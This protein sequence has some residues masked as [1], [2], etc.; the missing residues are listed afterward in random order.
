MLQPNPLSQLKIFI[1]P[2]VA[3]SFVTNLVVLVSPIFMMQVLD[4]VVPSG[5]LNTLAMLLMVAIGA[6]TTH[7]FTEFFKEQSLT[8][9]A[10]WIEVIGYKSALQLTG[11]TR[12]TALENTSKI[13][14]FFSGTTASTLLNT[15]WIPLF[16]GALYLIH[17]YFLLLLF[18]IILSI[19][20][21]KTLMQIFTQDTLKLSASYMQ[22][23]QQTLKDISNYRIV[24]GLYAITENL[25]TLFT[26]IQAQRHQN[27]NSVTTA[28]SIRNAI[29]GFLRMSSQVLALALGASLVVTGQLS[30]G[31]MIGASII[32]AKTISTIEASINSYQDIKRSYAAYLGLSDTLTQKHTVATEVKALSGALRA[33]GLIFPRGGGASPRIDRISFSLTSGECLAIIGDSGSGKT[34]LLHALCGIAP[35]PIGSTFFDESEVR[36]FGPVTKIKA[37]GYLPQQ[38]QLLTGTLA[39]NIS[40]FKDAPA[41]DKIIN[42]AKTAGVHGLISALP[43]AYETDIGVNPFLLSAGQKQRVAL[44]RAIFESPAYLF[45]DEPNALLDAAGERQLCDTLA[46]LKAKGTTIIMVLHRSGIMGLADKV[47]VLDNGKT[48]D[49]GARSEVLGRMSDGRTRLEIPLNATSMQDL[50]DWIV[51]QFS[52][53]SDMA[54]CQKAVLVGVE[55][56][57]AA[58]QNGAQDSP[59]HA[60]FVFKFLNEHCCEIVLHEK[61]PTSATSKMQK[62]RSLVRHP[63]VNMFDLPPDEIALAVISQLTDELEVKNIDQSSLFCAKISSDKSLLDGVS[64]H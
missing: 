13:S 40:C 57:N 30:A 1:L 36:T 5:N 32:M 44:A 37:I 52:R 19:L 34:T 63:E 15:F 28:I 56:F 10:R 11:T 54:F 64:K 17:P 4:R 59:R 38:A 9:T 12:Q 48:N 61:M 45:L 16:L 6:I 3:F 27:E 46:T 21:I 49:F 53:H 31:G 2:L 7:A 60:T 24:S 62:I 22:S 42:A 26:S 20:V 14:K 39:Q 25:R 33:E 23:E 51:A 55:I 43:D 29:L 47:L 41:D 8:K 58:C 35:C 50:N 18:G